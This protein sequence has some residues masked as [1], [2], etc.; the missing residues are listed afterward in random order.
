MIKRTELRAAGLIGVGVA[1]P[2]DIAR[3]HLPDQPGDYAL[4]L[5]SKWTICA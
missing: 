3:A 1:F 2:D 4:G 5:R